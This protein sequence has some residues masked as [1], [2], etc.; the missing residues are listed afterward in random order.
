[1]DNKEIEPVNTSSLPLTSQESQPPLVVDLPD[2]QK[3]VVGNLDPG[4]VVEVATWRGTGRPDSRTNRLMLGVT[5]AEGAPQQKQVEAPAYV[6]STAAVRTGI[7]YSE[8]NPGAQKTDMA[9]ISQSKP[10]RSRKKLF[11]TI[12]GSVAIVSLLVTLFVW[13]LGMRVAHPQTGAGTALGGASSTLVITRPIGELKTGQNVIADLPGQ[14]FNPAIA[15]V[16]AVSGENILLSTGTGF[17]QVEPLNV[18]GSIFI[19]LPFIGKI[20]DL[21]S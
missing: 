2:G 4:T 18:R 3:L 7:I 17:S 11:A 10:A 19:V 12:A 6:E 20:F 9:R 5:N 14:E 15:V 21:F 16:S 1:M 8:L 13:P